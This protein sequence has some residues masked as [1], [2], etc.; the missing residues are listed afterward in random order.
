MATLSV[1]AEHAGL[2]LGAAAPASV[3]IEGDPEQLTVLLNNLVENALR[4]TPAGG[5]V[6]VEARLFDGR[7]ELRVSDSGPGIAPAER[8][9][10]FDRFYRCDAASGQAGDS[11]GGG[12]GLAIVKAIAE[13][14]GASV[15]LA[16]AA[17]G[18][19]L[20]VRV[21]FAPGSPSPSLK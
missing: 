11:G 19:G 2:D 7:A 12:L 16:T 5:T 9:R 6:D 8:E 10:V 14:Y 18:A 4:Y 17:S 21:V 13:R 3:L 15:S 20:E 1:K